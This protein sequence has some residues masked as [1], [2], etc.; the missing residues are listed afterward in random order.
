MEIADQIVNAF[1]ELLLEN[2]AMRQA[3]RET[4]RDL[5]VLLSTAKSDPVRRQLVADLLAPLRM[6]IADEVEVERRLQEL[7]ERLK[8]NPGEAN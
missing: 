5:E 2:M 3:L 1:S 6:A 4:T 8:D 7:M